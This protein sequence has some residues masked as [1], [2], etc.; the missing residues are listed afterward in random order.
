MKVKK[1][2]EQYSSVVEH[3]LSMYKELGLMPAPNTRVMLG[4][5]LLVIGISNFSAVWRKRQSYVRSLPTL[6]GPLNEKL[7]LTKVSVLTTCAGI[8]IIPLGGKT[9]PCFRPD[10]YSLVVLKCV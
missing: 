9:C 7:F 2:G 10:V 4:L 1:R 6:L 3:M 5:Q 8:M